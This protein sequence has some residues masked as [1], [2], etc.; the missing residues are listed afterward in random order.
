MRKGQTGEAKTD[1]MTDELSAK[2]RFFPFFFSSFFLVLILLSFPLPGL[3]EKKFWGKITL[4]CSGFTMVVPSL[5]KGK[6]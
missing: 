3:W 6:G 2:I 4:P 1:G 5:N